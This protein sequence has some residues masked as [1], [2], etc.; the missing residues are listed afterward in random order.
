LYGAQYLEKDGDRVMV[1]RILLVTALMATVAPAAITNVRLQGAPTPTQAVLAYTAP[2]NNPCAVSISESP[3]LTP[4]VP[5]VDPSLFFGVD[6]D[7]QRDGTSV[8]GQARAVVI[9]KRAVELALDG[10]R[11]S[12][13]LQAFT[14][15]YYRLTCGVDQAS[16]TF[17]TENPP[18]GNTYNDPVFDR[19]RPGEYAMATIDWVDKTKTYTDPH[20]GVLVKRMGGPGELV[21]TVTPVTFS[22][23]SALGPGWTIAGL[24]ASFTGA[25]RAFVY[26]R[27]SDPL[28]PGGAIGKF[29]DSVQFNLVGA[30]GAATDAADRTVDL[31]I[32]ND[33]V[34]CSGKIVQQV[35]TSSSASYTVG[36]TAP[37]LEFWRASPNVPS[38]KHDIRVIKGSVTLGA[39]G[40][41][42]TWQNGDLFS[43]N[44]SPGS[45][46]TLD[47]VDCAIQSLTNDILLKLASASCMTV[48]THSYAGRNWGV[49][50]RKSSPST[51]VITITSA[52]WNLGTSG[53]SGFPAAGGY[54]LCSPVATAGPT[55]N[56]Y[57]C[58]DGGT[59]AQYLS[60]NTLY[61]VG[62]DGTVNPIG[63][64]SGN[65]N[66][67]AQAGFCFSG[68]S[69][70][71]DRTKPGLYYCLGRLASNGS[72]VIFSVQYT[73]S[74]AP[75]AVPLDSPL[76]PATTTVLSGDIST[77]VAAR[78]PAFSAFTCQFGWQMIGREHDNLILQCTQSGQNTPAWMVVYSI[79]QNTIIAATSTYGGSQ[80]AANRWSTAHSV[81][82]TGDNDWILLSD[83]SVGDLPYQTAIASGTL[84]SN[85]TSCPLT[86]IDPTAAGRVQC[87]IVTIASLVPAD[88]ISGLTLLGQALLPGDFFQV[89]RLSGTSWVSD[90]E[91]VRVLAL[92]GHT[93]TVER[94][95]RLYSY[96]GNSN[97]IGQLALQ[98]VPGAIH[99]IWWNY[100]DDPLGQ[101]LKKPYGLTLLED[102]QSFD[103]HQVYNLGVFIAGCLKFLPLGR[104]GAAIRVG[105]LPTS[106]STT[107]SFSDP[108]FFSNFDAGFSGSQ[109]QIIT[110]YNES[111]PSETQYGATPYERMAI[112][113]A[114]PYLGD[115]TI[116]TTSSVTKIAGSTYLYKVAASATGNLKPRLQP[117]L[118]TS[119][120]HP[121]VDVSPAVLLDAPA[122]NYKGCY[123]VNTND[124]RAGSAPG[125]VY[126]NVPFAAAPYCFPSRFA[127]TPTLSDVC[128]TVNTNT[129]QHVIQSADFY[130]DNNGALVRRLA[131]SFS[132][133][134]TESPFWNV[135]AT[136][137]AKWV[138]APVANVGGVR[139]ELMMMKVPPLPGLESVN[140]GDF[141]TVPVT[142]GPSP[143]NPSARAR[144]GYAENGA[145]SNFYC[146]QRQVDC[147]TS[148]PAGTPFVWSDEAQTP[149]AC[150]AGCK[151]NIPALPGRVL[152]YVIERQN[153]G[154]VWIGGAMQA[155][156]VK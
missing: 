8:S 77:M 28:W 47:G 124:C 101:M 112:F 119:G 143:G 145:S 103:C 102:P 44:W 148:A 56:G 58:A 90:A 127:A 92:S 24:Q 20:S 33:G 10:R 144:F 75:V 88:P 70:P 135:R 107:N 48:G 134:K 106:T 74:Y 104:V 49:L 149:Q 76:S 62:D 89:M 121:V 117:L 130:D 113:D 94:L 133:Y 37:I 34:T 150:A 78:N 147:T 39:D 27:A 151:I 9:G 122:D 114:R 25:S 60:S 68:Q 45:L 17:V 128:V 108:I 154:G 152:Y 57:I 132:P 71:W 52:N 53:Y 118:L 126:M 3:T 7:L 19:S 131:N 55:G 63:M 98:P 6:T 32:T 36:D 64:G 31:C 61:W 50:I 4:L 137:N 54:D 26:Y 15:H 139:V 5:D 153:S 30:S 156:A 116:A 100:V 21:P 2:D 91:T 155:I 51:D 42:V 93:A 67:L 18:F 46:I 87:S 142:L 109:Y 99:E 141:E 129:V 83:G 13:S 138:F 11:H 16:G 73:G 72:Y 1:N 84:T 115:P 40:T 14:R 81:F 41:T 136:P 22:S 82:T 110:S 12:R 43:L 69:W 125:E 66:A 29:T 95:V 79:P 105:P 65:N 86:P 146:T 38:T 96:A 140:R 97:H 59:I 111:H 23:A 35:L 85:F 80:G 120:V 123:V